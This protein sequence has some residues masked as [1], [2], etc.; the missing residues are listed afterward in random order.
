M[1]LSSLLTFICWLLNKLY[2]LI[3]FFY[4]SSGKKYSDAFSMCM[5]ICLVMSI[6]TVYRTCLSHRLSKNWVAIFC[7][8]FYVL[9]VPL[10]PTLLFHTD[11][12]S[13]KSSALHPNGVCTLI[14]LI[15]SAHSFPETLTVNEISSAI[16][17]SYF[18]SIYYL[19]CPWYLNFEI[20]W[21]TLAFGKVHT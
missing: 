3:F 17:G 7:P 16:W 14:S 9:F 1:R 5:S 4:T 8:C 10:I 20:L 6:S 18:Y 12:K 11:L 13:Q 2:L 15:K 21:K 19:N